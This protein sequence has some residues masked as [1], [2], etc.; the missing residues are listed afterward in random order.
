MKAKKGLVRAANKF[1]GLREAMALAAEVSSAAAE[2]HA[3]FTS[4]PSVLDDSASALIT[5]QADV[6]IGP[7]PPGDETS[8][9]AEPSPPKKKKKRKLDEASS[10]PLLVKKV[11][12][13]KVKL[14]QLPGKNTLL[15][16]TVAKKRKNAAAAE[17]RKKAN[18]TVMHAVQD[19]DW[20]TMSIQQFSRPPHSD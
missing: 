3:T 20:R 14:S 4:F 6:F 11:K 13:S 7:A 9:I 17:K 16:N 15:G 8:T 19:I 1:K 12:S 10:T 5:D 18:A 2:V